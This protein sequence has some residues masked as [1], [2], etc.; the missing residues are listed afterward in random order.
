MNSSTD[1]YPLH[2]GKVT[3]ATAEDGNISVIVVVQLARSKELDADQIS[4]SI[5][6]DE[7]LKFANRIVGAVNALNERMNR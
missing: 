5:S 6:K 4:F 7:A 3:S 1:D 2:L